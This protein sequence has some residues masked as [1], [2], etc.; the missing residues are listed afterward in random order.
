MPGLTTF[1]GVMGSVCKTYFF[2]H[3][4]LIIYDYSRF[5]LHAFEFQKTIWTKIIFKD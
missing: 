5:L 2:I 4:N 3:R 1:S